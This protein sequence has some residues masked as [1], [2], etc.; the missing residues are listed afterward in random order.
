MHTLLIDDDD[1]GL[2]LTERLLKREDVFDKVTAFSSAEDALTFLQHAPDNELPRVVF[3]DLN[4]P[5]MDGWEFLDALRPQEARLQGRCLIYILT[6]S[7]AQSD[8]SRAQE[9]ALVAGLLH[10]PIDSVQI[11]T[12]L[13][14]LA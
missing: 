11:Q 7:L 4:M 10:K 6:S 2:F 13:A 14:T 1:I 8:T 9:F 12:V 3:L 5:V